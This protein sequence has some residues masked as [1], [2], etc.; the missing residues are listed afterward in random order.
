MSSRQLQHL[1][2][3]SHV[4]AFLKKRG[5]LQILGMIVLVALFGLALKSERPAK[6]LTPAE[7]WEVRGSASSKVPLPS[8]PIQFRQ[9]RRSATESSGGFVFR[10]WTPELGIAPLEVISAPFRPSSYM[11]VAITGNNRTSIGSNQAFIEC[12]ANAKKLDIF[13]GSVGSHVDE[14]LIKLPT[15]W[16]PGSARLRLIA[17]EP[18]VNVGAGAVFKIS[19]LSYWKSTTIGRLPYLIAACAIFSLFMLAGASLGMRLGR[20]GDPFPIAL[21]ALGLAA[22]GALYIAT[23]LPTD[24]RWTGIVGMGSLAILALL[25]A[26]REARDRAMR[27]LAPYAKVWGIAGLIYFSILGLAA[28]GL[29]HGEPAYRFWPA[30][31]SADK[32]SA[33]LF[34]EAVHKGWNLAGLFGGTPVPTDYPPLMTGA[35]LLL[36]DAFGWLQINNDGHYLQGPAYNAAA[37]A[38]STLWAPVCWWLLANLRPNLDRQGRTAILVFIG[39]LPFALFATSY[40]SSKT[41]AII[42]ALAAFGTVWQLGATHGAVSRQK[43]IALACVLAAFGILADTSSILFIAPLGLVLL[44]VNRTRLHHALP[45]LLVAAIVIAS[46]S[47]YKA[48]VLPSA[49]PMIK[50]LLTGDYGFGHPELSIWDLVAKHY[51]SLEPWQWLDIKGA[52]FLQAFTPLSH[53]IAQ[54][55]MNADHGSSP[56]E[57]L[58]AWDLLMLSKGNL[59][60]PI[61]VVLA[62]WAATKAFAFNFSD[63]IKANAPF[64]AI[65]VL[66]LIAWLLMVFGFLTPAVLPQWPQ[67]AFWGLALGGVTIV[68]GRYPLLFKVLLLGV[69]TYTLSV[70]ILSPLTSALN[71]DVVAAIIFTALGSWVFLGELSPLRRSPTTTQIDATPARHGLLTALKANESIQRLG[72]LPCWSLLTPAFAIAA[73]LFA[74]FITFRYIG[75]PLVDGNGFRQTQ[76]ALTAYWMLK[77]GWQLAYQTPVAGFPWSI[78]FEF[79]LYQALVVTI[80]KL[81]DFELTAAGRLVSYVFLVACGWPAFAIS[82][83]LNL[84]AAVPWVFCALLWTS[85]LNVFWGRTFMIETMALFFSFACIPFA[86]DLIRKH[87]D[88]RSTLLFLLLAT[89]GILQK[90]TTAGPVLLFLVCGCIIAQVRPNGFTLA[91]LRRLTYPLSVFGIPLLIG[92]F[93]SHYSDTVKAENLL[94][95]DLTSKSLFIWNFGTIQQKLS[96]ETW[97][98]I[99]WERTF[100]DNAAGPLGLILLLLPWLSGR[101]YRY[102]AWLSLAAIVLFLLPLLI[103]TNLHFVHNYYQ[104]SCVLFLIA[105]L[106]IIIGGWLQMASGVAALTPLVTTV[107]MACNLVAFYKGYGIVAARPLAEQDPISVQNYALGSYLRDHTETATGLVIF[108]QSW[109]SEVAFQAQRKSLTAPPGFSEYRQAWQNPQAYLGDLKLGAIVVCPSEG[110][111][112]GV[113]DVQKRLDHEPGWSLQSVGN[114][115]V[116]L[117]NDAR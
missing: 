28:N 88:A 38:L 47:L 41:F 40:G 16:C 98:V 3:G 79:P 100:L 90:A 112:P 37:V 94:G 111:F 59:A 51:D 11:S 22:L 92:L 99:I 86:I 48:W 80:S 74:G 64:V 6:L 15:N 52:M 95:R 27:A 19:S 93:W 78:P 49:N 91:T 13:R 36:A 70:W 30:V 42:Y 72:N 75:E 23:A 71:V 39:C 45:G 10:T 107:F 25:L 84:P 46:W 33:W 103:F 35:Y 81:F 96:L 63:T 83:R 101:N 29:G 57:Q 97:R 110:N 56:F 2:A 77:E 105:A 102:F 114:C 58:R 62:L 53:S 116:L 108:G 60:V 76:T 113:S 17:A 9:V 7:G 87:S 21:T 67:A 12:I 26:G 104:T 61:M 68:Y 14:A 54:I 69:A 20:H 117:P 73:L 31:W 109:D 44:I 4:P 115:Q 5:F 65:I 50:Y 82:R 85:P 66:S 8:F 1:R 55:A 18:D 32:E 106:S 24:Q 34:A 89:A 43:G